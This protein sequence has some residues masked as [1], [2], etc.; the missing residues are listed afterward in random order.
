MRTASPRRWRRLPV[1]H[2]KAVSP[3][4]PQTL[5]PRLVIY[6]TTP[7][8]TI[9]FELQ[10]N[11][12]SEAILH[13]LVEIEVPLVNKGIG[14]LAAQHLPRM[15]QID[16]ARILSQP[17][18]G[19]FLFDG[20]GIVK[21]KFQQGIAHMAYQQYASRTKLWRRTVYREALWFDSIDFTI[22]RDAIKGEHGTWKGLRKVAKES[23]PRGVSKETAESIAKAEPLRWDPVKTPMAYLRTEVMR[24]AVTKRGNFMVE[25][26]D[27]FD[28]KRGF[29][30]KF[31][32]A[33]RSD[34][35][36]EA[37]RHIIITNKR[38]GTFSAE[39]FE[40]DG[41][42]LLYVPVKYDEKDMSY[43]AAT[44]VGVDLGYVNIA[45][46]AAVDPK[47]RLLLRPKFWH[48]GE[49]AQRLAVLWA[50]SAGL[51]SKRREPAAVR[52]YKRYWTYRTCHEVVEFVKRFPNP[53]IAIEDLRG[54]YLTHTDWGS[55]GNR[56][57]SSWD[58]GRMREFLVH[59]GAMEGIRV[60]EVTARGTSSTCPHC[61]SKIH[62]D[63]R[64]HQSTCPACGYNNND[65]LIGAYNI[66]LRGA[67][68]EPSRRPSTGPDERDISPPVPS[69]STS[70]TV[71]PTG[72]SPSSVGSEDSNALSS[73]GSRR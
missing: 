13:R 52:T 39:L 53:V 69:S 55:R 62:R 3:R 67:T 47:T 65:D 5:R 1:A 7:S 19:T 20:T 25:M 27:P 9:S 38:G 35:I 49:I 42:F 48:G 22:L 17:A 57:R 43:E 11:R 23:L 8:R 72:G 54:I 56:K 37:I 24:F 2:A 33:G 71:H 61:G 58:Y 12:R 14:V 29:R 44:Y 45:V 28:L 36:E 59:L 68:K 60:I 73:D 64:Q 46:A 15:S 18:L 6:L 26:T 40:R 21:Q 63:R 41:R 50:R 51:Q 4:L 34:Y 16:A 66:A 10:G 30:L 70:P 32:V 31:R